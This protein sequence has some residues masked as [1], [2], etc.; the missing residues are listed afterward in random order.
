MTGEPQGWL[1][2][3]VGGQREDRVR[4]ARI[5]GSCRPR[6]PSRRPGAA[7]AAQLALGTVVDRGPDE[8]NKSLTLLVVHSAVEAQVRTSLLR[9]PETAFDFDDRAGVTLLATLGLAFRIRHLT[10]A[11]HFDRSQ[12]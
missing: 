8:E 6:E 10:R 2:A 3:R 4:G 1:G 9:T 12:A 5:V 11:T 7:R